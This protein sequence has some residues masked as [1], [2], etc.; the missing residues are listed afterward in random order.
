M[1]VYVVRHGETE[2]NRLR[3][4]QGYQEI[5][6]NDHGIAQAAQLGRR[7]ASV[8]LDHIVCSDLRRAVMTGC[9]VAA[10]TGV[11]M[12]Y[13]TGLRERDPGTLVE[14]YYDEHPAFF[15][16]PAYVPPSGEG[17]DAFRTRV[18][19]CFEGLAAQYGATCGHL[20]VVT[21]GLVCH[22]F[23]DSFFGATASMGVGSANTMMTV[24]RVDG[25]GWHLEEAGCTAHLEGTAGSSRGAS[26]GA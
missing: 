5:P 11:P 21:H 19:A 16:D 13:E 22:A 8:P 10:Y 6:L 12:S 20:L 24:A 14:S 4:M 18:T 9:I 23:V 25:A 26:P 3:K 1:K 17:V 7:L 2:Y 15:T